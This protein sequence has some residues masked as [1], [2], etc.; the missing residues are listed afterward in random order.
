M[1][2]D[3]C[4]HLEV[5]QYKDTCFK[6]ENSTKP[7]SVD[8]HFKLVIECKHYKRPRPTEKIL[9]DGQIKKAPKCFNY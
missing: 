2:C 3:D 9:F 1:T 4:L 7:Y 8:S 6:L 5:C